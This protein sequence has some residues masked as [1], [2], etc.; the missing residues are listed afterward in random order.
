M[1][2][3]RD[4][5]KLRKVPSIN[6]DTAVF[7]HGNKDRKKK[8]NIFKK[9]SKAPEDYTKE[10]IQMAKRHMT[11]HSTPI[12][13]KATKMETMRFRYTVARLGRTMGL[14]KLNVGKEV[15][16]QNSG[17]AKWHNHFGKPLG[18]F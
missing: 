9:M 8:T 1:R 10:N 3:P 14:T 2:V 16:D 13:I 6:G 4:F 12:V 7:V 15:S 11:E 18:S 17:D 5:I